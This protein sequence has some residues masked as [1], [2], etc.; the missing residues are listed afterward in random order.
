MPS[1]KLFSIAYCRAPPGQPL[2]HAHNIQLRSLLHIS[3]GSLEEIGPLL[4]QTNGLE[5]L[6]I[7]C[8]MR[9]DIAFQVQATLISAILTHKETFR[10]LDLEIYPATVASSIWEDA[11]IRQQK[12]ENSSSSGYE[13]PNN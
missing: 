12:C 3:S 13:G 8:A 11:A 10:T 5:N 7:V 6:V 4:S 9:L 1:L 2:I